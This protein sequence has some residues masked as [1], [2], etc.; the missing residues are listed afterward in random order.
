MSV[1]T[2][3]LKVIITAVDQKTSLKPNQ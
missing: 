1:M 2:S 3:E